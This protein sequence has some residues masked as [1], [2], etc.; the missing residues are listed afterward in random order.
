[1]SLLYFLKTV[2]EVSAKGAYMSFKD[3]PDVKFTQKGFLDK[4][5]NDEGFRNIFEE[6]A[7]KRLVELISSNYNYISYDQD[8]YDPNKGIL[9][10]L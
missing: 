6:A 4:L 10:S 9:G 8:D 1:M 7:K 2:G 5:D 3:Y